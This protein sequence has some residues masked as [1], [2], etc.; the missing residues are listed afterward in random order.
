MSTSKTLDIAVS[1]PAN[2][3]AWNAHDRN[4][5]LGLF[6]TAIGAGTL[7]LPINAGLGGIW[8]LLI[9]AAARRPRGT[10]A[11]AALRRTPLSSWYRS[12]S[13]SAVT[14]TCRRGEVPQRKLR[15]VTVATLGP[16]LAPSL[17][18]MTGVIV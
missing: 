8:P 17:T 4:W 9:M 5:V 18:T 12:P 16:K 3:S 1:C 14:S 15:K 10:A 2:E 6:A 7:F 13:M 11:R